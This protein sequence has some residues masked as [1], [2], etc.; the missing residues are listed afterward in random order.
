MSEKKKV[1]EATTTAEQTVGQM[2]IADLKDLVRQAIREEQAFHL[3]DKGYLVFHNEAAYTAYLHTQPDKYPSEIR[4]YFIDEHGFKVYY[5]DYEPTP[6][7]ARDLEKARREIAEEKTH[8]FED[9]IAELG[10]E[11]EDV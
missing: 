8:R 1:R 9:V 2:S 5:S 10:L 7:K 11:D 4:A 6:E 3:D